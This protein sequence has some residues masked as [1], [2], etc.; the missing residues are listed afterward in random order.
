MFNIIFKFYKLF[1]EYIGSHNLYN[2]KDD[3]NI[4]FNDTYD[5]SSNYDEY[6]EENKENEN[7]KS[8]SCNTSN[9]DD[10]I[11]IDGLE[12]LLLKVIKL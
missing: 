3:N 1:N 10:N 8:N 6:I 4:V 9:D 12:L 11:M 2:I 7:T 5:F